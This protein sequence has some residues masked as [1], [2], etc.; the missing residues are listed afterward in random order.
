M[1]AGRV[2]SKT[3]TSTQRRTRGMCIHNMIEHLSV[4]QTT[5]TSV[6]GTAVTHLDHDKANSHCIAMAT[7]CHAHA[8]VLR[9]HRLHI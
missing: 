2:T 5:A 3:D 7:H 4:N 6:V 9:I 1:M 8:Y